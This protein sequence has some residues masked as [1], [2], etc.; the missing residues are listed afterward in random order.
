MEMALWRIQ[1]DRPRS[2]A[3]SGIGE[4]Q[5]LES[6]I[7]DDVE[8]LGLGPLML[9]GRQVLTDHGSRVD[10]LAL[11][12][13]G[14]VYVI[15]L[16][17]DR[18]PRDVVAQ[19]LDYGSWI[20]RLSAERLAH[21][22]ESGRFARDSMFSAAFADRFGRPLPDVINESHRLVIVASQLDEST[23][24]IVEYLLEGFGVPV[25]AVFFR[26]F[27]DGTSEY[28]AR[29]WLS[30]PAVAEQ[31]ALKPKRPPGE[32]NGVDYYVLFAPEESR[33]WED[34]REWRYVSAGGGSRWSNS[35]FRLRPGA[36]VFVHLPQ[37]G[38]V[39]VGR[40]MAEPVPIG[41]FV[42]KS[43]DREVS[44]LDVPLRNESI[45]RH[46]TDPELAEYLVAVDWEWDVPASEGY[47]ERGFFWRRGT[48]VVEL[49][50]PAT[51]RKICAHAGIPVDEGEGAEA[52]ATSKA[53]IPAR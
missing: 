52:Q 48:T 24:R 25:N 34:A 14:T 7:A 32:W 15:E 49:R 23:Q 46:A 12:E 47:W 2:L 18:T 39:A 19:V 1:D 43:G 8:I 26:Y 37:H 17:R 6:I 27:R 9:L 50:D 4:E 10:L 5:R 51:T 35:L 11:D 41:E 45:K 40:V 29:T 53:S 33:S 21:I 20:R 36:R 22:F 31:R 38:Y 44:L 42:V 13:E 30:D 3:A 28:L 16:K